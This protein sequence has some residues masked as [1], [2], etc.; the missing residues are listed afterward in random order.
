MGI[1]ELSA[2]IARAKKSGSAGAIVQGDLDDIDACDFVLVNASKPSWGTAMEV[3]YA[4]SRAKQV[5]AFGV[6]L[7]SLSP[8]LSY[9]CDGITC[10]L[11]A[12]CVWIRIRSGGDR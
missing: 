6:S 4:H 3:F 2:M 12:A 5:V 7:N 8:W 9:H 10:D 1:E 11:E